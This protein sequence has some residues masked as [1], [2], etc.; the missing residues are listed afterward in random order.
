MALTLEQWRAADTAQVPS[1][2]GFPAIEIKRF[3]GWIWTTSEGR[4]YRTNQEGEGRWFITSRGE[5]QQ[6]L[7]TM[8]F[9]LPADYK[10][11]LRELK[12]LGYK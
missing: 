10:A 11:A 7:G 6:E 3:G 1:Q 2:N 8:Q 12:R 5:H 9:A 4:T